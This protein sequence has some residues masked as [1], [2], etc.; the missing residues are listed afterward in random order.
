LEV[1]ASSRKTPTGIVC[2]D[3]IL[4]GFGGVGEKR[5]GLSQS[6]RETIAGNQEAI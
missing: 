4:G 3:F 1:R 5:P 2:N 6:P